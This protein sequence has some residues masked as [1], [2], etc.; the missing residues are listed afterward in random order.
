MFP[1]SPTKQA[2]TLTDKA[3]MKSARNL[4]LHVVERGKNVLFYSVLLY[5]D[6]E[7]NLSSNGIVIFDVIVTFRF[8]TRCIILIGQ[9]TF[10]I[11]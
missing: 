10:N 8:N 1:T 11:V 9:L 3:T 6:R 7:K 5:I 2:C 4:V